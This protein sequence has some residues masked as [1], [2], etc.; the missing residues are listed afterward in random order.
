MFQERLRI[1]VQLILIIHNVNYMQ[2]AILPQRS[3]SIVHAKKIDTHLLNLLRKPSS[4]R[5]HEPQ[6]IHDVR[7]C[8]PASHQRIL[9]LSNFFVARLF[10]SGYKSVFKPN[11]PLKFNL[12]SGFR[13]H[14]CSQ[15][16]QRFMSCIKNEWHYLFF[17]P[18][19][20]TGK[21]PPRKTVH[22]KKEEWQ[23]RI[24]AGKEKER[25]R[26]RE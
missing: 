13:A 1:T 5:K 4:L 16:A 11:V 10:Y 7:N 24:K 19:S 20:L 17:F 22:G 8:T 6:Q 26:M 15:D 9:A 23:R 3:M 14:P 18:P 2:T 12:A 25:E 21:V